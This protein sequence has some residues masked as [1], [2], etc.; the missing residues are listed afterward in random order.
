MQDELPLPLVEEQ[1]EGEITAE[2]RGEDREGDGLGQP[3]GTDNLRRSRLGGAFFWFGG[4]VRHRR[5]LF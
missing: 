4:W 3:D 1:T 2:K 5:F